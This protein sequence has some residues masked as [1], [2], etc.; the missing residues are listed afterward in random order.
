MTRK[1]SVHSRI[2]SLGN[3]PKYKHLDDKK[4]FKICSYLILDRNCCHFEP[5]GSL[6]RQTQ[7]EPGSIPDCTS[8]EFKDEVVKLEGDDYYISKGIEY[9]RLKSDLCSM[10][11]SSGLK[12]ATSLQ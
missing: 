5:V 3:L 10:I 8:E 7:P 4:T 9:V 12:I 2:F 6:I 11:M 1:V